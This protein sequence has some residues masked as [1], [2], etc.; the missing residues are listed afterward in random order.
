MCTYGVVMRYR[1]LVLSETNSINPLV[2]KN[3]SEFILS[4]SNSIDISIGDRLIMGS[5]IFEVYKRNFYIEDMF[6]VDLIVKHVGKRLDIKSGILG[7]SS[8]IG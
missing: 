2:D 3:N 7:S 8:K 5:D 6:N 4:V 1:L